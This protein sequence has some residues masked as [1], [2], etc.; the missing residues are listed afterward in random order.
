MKKGQNNL[1]PENIE[2]FF[3]AL[4]ENRNDLVIEMLIDSPEL[5]NSQHP[6]FGDCPLA[7]LINSSCP[8][9]VGTANSILEFQA[10][11]DNL[12]IDFTIVNNRG[13][14]L[15]DSFDQIRDLNYRDQFLSV[16]N[17]HGIDIFGFHNAVEVAEAKKNHLIKTGFLDIF[18]HS[19]GYKKF[20]DHD[21]NGD[22]TVNYFF[23]SS[24]DNAIAFNNIQHEKFLNQYAEDSFK[25]LDS[26][27]FYPSA[28]SQEN[29]ELFN[30]VILP[31]N[32]EAFVEK[33]S[34]FLGAIY[35]NFDT[36]D[37]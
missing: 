26:I 19:F 1:T 14:N 27:S 8:L 18:S 24:D 29:S 28:F 15:R 36:N 2:K 22:A 37:Q 5:I 13:F 9:N 11:Q 7:F 30:I 23:D 35:Q 32:I 20:G 3:R 16:F 25:G 34:Q 31:S 12:P 21:E 10:T 6:V 33:L 17:N 4:T